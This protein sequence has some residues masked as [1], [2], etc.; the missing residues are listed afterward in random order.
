[1]GVQLNW[2]KSYLLD[3][4]Q[5]TYNQGAYSTISD[6]VCGVP[7]GTVLGPLLFL[8]YINDIS[9]A[10]KNGN[11]RLFA[12]DSNIFIVA[13]NICYCLKIIFN[14]L[15]ARFQALFV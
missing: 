14:I 6:S 2:F 7:Q 12:D 5:S 3:R 4:S 15:L 13:D 11:I 10:T 1:R 8:I 9:A